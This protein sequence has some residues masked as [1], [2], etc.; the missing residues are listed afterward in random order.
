M[1]HVLQIL[2]IRL[3]AHNFFKNAV[4]KKIVLFSTLKIIIFQIE[5][6]CLRVAF[7]FNVLKILEIF[8]MFVLSTM[9]A[10][11]WAISFMNDI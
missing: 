11:T 3:L 6:S 5:Q 7:P 2:S 10:S 4:L 8:K 1:E 9:V